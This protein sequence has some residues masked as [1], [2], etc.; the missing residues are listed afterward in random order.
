[1]DVDT[2]EAVVEVDVVEEAAAVDEAEGDVGTTTT[3][4]AARMVPCNQHQWYRS[5]FST[6][7]E[8]EFIFQK[9]QSSV[10][11]IDL[12]NCCATGVW[13]FEFER[14]GQV[15]CKRS[16]GTMSDQPLAMC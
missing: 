8:L 14:N 15:L 16:R 9:S 13:D 1:M 5:V 4:A 11:M 10:W 2:E 7:M 12:G 3:V 6:P